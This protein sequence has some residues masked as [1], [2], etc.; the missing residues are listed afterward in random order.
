MKIE[1]V[2]KNSSLSSLYPLLAVLAGIIIV[3]SFL[4]EG[5]FRIELK[6]GILFGILIDII[7]L[8][9]PIIIMAL[10]MTFI[11]A[12]DGIDL[13]VAGVLHMSMAIC[14]A[15]IQDY[16]D[17]S[18]F[19]YILIP[20]L[21][22]IAAGAVNGFLIAIIR[23]QA[24]MATLIVMTIT[25]GV[26]VL[27]GLGGKVGA[28]SSIADHEGFSFIGQG[29]LFTIPFPVIL[30]IVFTAIVVLTTRKTA[31]GLFIKAS[32]ANETA[33]RYMGINVKGITFG[34]YVF[35]AILACIGGLIYLADVGAVIFYT[36]DFSIDLDVIACVFIGGTIG[37]G[38]YSL[39]GTVI[40]AIFLQLLS[41]TVYTLGLPLSFIDV[42]RALLIILVIV[43]QAPQV[44]Q[45]VR[46][47]AMG[48]EKRENESV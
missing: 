11:I 20:I 17:M 30:A 15:L 37:G 38:K 26:G 46:K 9:A 33:A 2:S 42:F 41:S 35:S 21:A 4:I 27:I 6:Q 40:G 23:V 12:Q 1:S 44:Q 22:A 24:L 43:L 18:I 10:A 3:D 32:G 47:M 31:L 34:I 48:R 16:P 5:L 8:G 14:A 13:S 25:A 39:I 45:F 36:I 28:R 7:N 19:L 29:S